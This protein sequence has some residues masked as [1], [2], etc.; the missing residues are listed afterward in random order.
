M[1]RQTQTYSAMMSELQTLL[2]EMQA[3]GLDI[4][5]AIVKYERGQ[6]LLAA[7]SAYLK[8]VENKVVHRKADISSETD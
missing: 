5:A 3:E 7:L 1:A 4:D 6:V 2:A 8:T